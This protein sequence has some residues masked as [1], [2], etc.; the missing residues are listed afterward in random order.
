MSI[1]GDFLF[2]AFFFFAKLWLIDS[3]F[4]GFLDKSLTDIVLSHS[5]HT[6]T[7]NPIPIHSLRKRIESVLISASFSIPIHF[8]TE[9]NCKSEP[10]GNGKR[11]LESIFGVTTIMQN[12]SI[13]NTEASIDISL[14]KASADVKL[15]REYEWDF[16]ATF[17]EHSE[18]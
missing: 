16:E 10:S 5:R 4:G 14:W 1:L 3:D 9:M 13:L 12:S 11:F 15:E 2:F 7:H 18:K 6:Q 17:Y 8:E